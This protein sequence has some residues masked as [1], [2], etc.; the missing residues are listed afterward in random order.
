MLRN[1]CTAALAVALAVTAPA[2]AA[3]VT[4]GPIVGDMAPDHVQIWGRTSDAAAVTV[5]YALSGTADWAGLAIGTAAGSDYTFSLPIPGLVADT[6]YDYRVLVD[7]G[8]AA[9]GTF[10]TA[11]P[12]GDSS[13]LAVAF[14][15]DAFASSS[16]TVWAAV[17]ARNP[18]GFFIIG[19][20]DRS[21][22]ATNTADAA[23][24]LTKLRAMHRRLRGPETPIGRD[25]VTNG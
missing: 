22:P 5:E 19:D 13:E 4:H 8:S 12:H 1:L 10:R 21:N 3:A 9:A 7:G 23:G 17:Q 11:P 14:V 24:Y 16:F 15:S 2:Y 20:F 6:A 18:D 25:F